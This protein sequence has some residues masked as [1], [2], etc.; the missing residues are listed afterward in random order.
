MSGLDS[1][2]KAMG[3]AQSDRQMSSS[4]LTAASRATPNPAAADGGAAAHAGGSPVDNEMDE[5]VP[6]VIA[7]VR[8]N[9]GV[10]APT[11]EPFIYRSGCLNKSVVDVYNNLSRNYIA[12]VDAALKQVGFEEFTMQMQIMLTQILSEEF[13]E[14]TEYLVNTILTY[15]GADSLFVSLLSKSML[16]QVIT[17]AQSIMSGN[18]YGMSYNMQSGGGGGGR[19]SEGVGNSYYRGAQQH[20]G[21]RGAGENGSSRDLRGSSVAASPPHQD[22]AAPQKPY[23]SSGL[24]PHSSDPGRER[25]SDDLRA[26]SDVISQREE[27]R[28]WGGGASVPPRGATA[29]GGIHVDSSVGPRGG[30]APMSGMGAGAASR[31]EVSVSRA[32]S[33]TTSGAGVVPRHTHHHFSSSTAAAAPAAKPSSMERGGMSGAPQHNLLP[34]RASPASSQP[35]VST[36]GA[37]SVS[38]ATTTSPMPTMGRGGPGIPMHHHHHHLGIGAMATNSAAASDWAASNSVSGSTPN[39]NAAGQ[40][41]LTPPTPQS[42][43]M[44]QHQHQHMQQQSQ[45]Q[46]PQPQQPTRTM[47]IPAPLSVQRRTEKNAAAAAAAAAPA[48]APANGSAPA[49]SSGLSSSSAAVEGGA[50]PRNMSAPLGGSANVPAPRGAQSLPHH[51]HHMPVSHHHHHHHHFV[52]SPPAVTA[53]VQPPSATHSPPASEERVATIPAESTG[54]PAPETNLPANQAS[55]ST[56]APARSPPATSVS[57]T[58]APPP[59][60]RGLG[61][62]PLHHHHHHMH[63]MMNKVDAASAPQRQPQ[64]IPATLQ[65]Q[66]QPHLPQPQQRVATA[67]D[68]HDQQ[69]QERT[70]AANGRWPNQK[71]ELRGMLLT[72]RVSESAVTYLLTDVN[73][74]ELRGLKYVD[75]EKKL[76]GGIPLMLDRQRIRQVLSSSAAVQSQSSDNDDSATSSNRKTA[77]S[78]VGA[79]EEEAGGSGLPRRPPAIST[80]VQSPV[81]SHQSSPISKAG[82]QVPQPRTKMQQQQ[83][84]QTQ[85][86]IN[87]G[88]AVASPADASFSSPEKESDKREGGT[89]TGSPTTASGAP[90]S[91]VPAS[92]PAPSPNS[93][94]SPSTRNEDPEDSREEEQRRGSGRRGG[95]RGGLGRGGFSSSRVCRFFGTAEG[96]QYGDKCH[97]MHSK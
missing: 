24:P 37:P 92:T 49:N 17:Y 77:T 34:P 40:R 25:S 6:P 88:S 57:T 89:K 39:I 70:N 46:L 60:L 33:E 93:S 53:A 4:S 16:D 5:H 87:G 23:R 86:S 19:G 42:A 13:G 67:I 10:L 35:R 44:Q 54:T 94:Y 11:I 28:D 75:F 95:K 68:V 51:Q 90:T 48:A 26:T 66:P 7:H 29:T 38:Q 20:H 30:A 14:D 21:Y 12:I 62:I 97:Y 71:E 64:P 8:K 72:A 32:T 1:H 52:A 69:Q 79:E 61:R 50:A 9:F 73:I 18:M 47:N 80:G 85:Q 45:Q 74:E 59:A 27:S 3:E 41:T 31:T 83:Q 36:P 96:C 84:Q 2:G 43:S 65:L 22:G 15:T 91:P 58:S 81:T 76:R 78:G 63:L 55:A 56:P 82:V